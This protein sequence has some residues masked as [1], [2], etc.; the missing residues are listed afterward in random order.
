[1]LEREEDAPHELPTKEEKALLRR[2][3]EWLKRLPAHIKSKLLGLELDKD[4]KVTLEDLLNVRR[5]YSCCGNGTLIKCPTELCPDD[6]IAIRTKRSRIWW[7]HMI[8]TDV[9]YDGFDVICPCKPSLD[10]K[11]VK[12]E[13]DYFNLR[14]LTYE[15]PSV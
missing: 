11:E 13:S 9:Y 5:I 14:D 4:G 3:I 8:V 12:F 6:H 1:M 15:S 10:P 2:F 7:N